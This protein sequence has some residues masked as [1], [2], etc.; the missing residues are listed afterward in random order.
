MAKK[1]GVAID[2]LRSPLRDTDAWDKLLVRLEEFLGQHRALPDGTESLTN[3]TSVLRRILPTRLTAFAL[4]ARCQLVIN[5]I[6]SEQIENS[7]GS[8]GRLGHELLGL[9]SHPDKIQSKLRKLAPLVYQLEIEE[10]ANKV[11]GRLGG[12]VTT[13]HLFDKL[14]RRF[15]DSATG[16]SKQ[17]SDTKLELIAYSRQSGISAKSDPPD[18]CLDTIRKHCN[19]IKKALDGTILQLVSEHRKKGKKYCSLQLR[20]NPPAV[21]ASNKARSKLSQSTRGRL[22]KGKSDLSKNGRRPK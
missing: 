16:D 6:L 9:A 5:E 7:T 10:I 13:I 1:F 19:Q 8:A 21:I 14:V 4:A 15:I 12:K 22:P 18:R 2:D 3:R 17:L 20:K 11:R